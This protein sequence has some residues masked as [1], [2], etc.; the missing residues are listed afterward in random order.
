MRGELRVV[1]RVAAPLVERT[2]V[3]HLRGCEDAEGHGG[4]HGVAD[5][6]LGARAVA[7]AQGI[8]VADVL[9]VA[10]ANAV[11]HGEHV[12]LVTFDG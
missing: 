11:D 5:A 12:T 2:H 3:E 6:V 10:R 9:A 8:E 7:P 4:G 1:G